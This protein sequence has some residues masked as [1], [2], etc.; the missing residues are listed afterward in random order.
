MERTRRNGEWTYT[1]KT[2][3]A[4]ALR[5]VGAVPSSRSYH[6]YSHCNQQPHR[7]RDFILRQQAYELVLIS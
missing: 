3:L 7:M 2:I 6:R 4:A 1:S 5:S